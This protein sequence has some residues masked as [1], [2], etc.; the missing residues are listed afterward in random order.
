MET[1]EQKR[2]ESC[3]Q[4][5]PEQTDDYIHYDPDQRGIL[6]RASFNGLRLT[7]ELP[8]V[9]CPNCRLIAAAPDLLEACKKIS[10]LAFMCAGPLEACAYQ[11]PPTKKWVC[12]E[13]P[14]LEARK[15]ALDECAEIVKAAI[16]LAEP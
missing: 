1:K 6:C 15:K 5:Y 10:S 4:V 11:G 13:A 3:G 8:S 12:D 9:T 14:K 16:A 7:T 2:C